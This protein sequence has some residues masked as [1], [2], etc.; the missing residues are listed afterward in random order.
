MGGTINQPRVN[1]SAG[2][3]SVAHALARRRIRASS[4]SRSCRKRRTARSTICPSI[5]SSTTSSCACR[6]TRCASVNVI[7]H[8]RFAYGID[9]REYEQHASY[10]GR[11]YED[12]Y[13]VDLATGERKL[14][15]KKRIPSRARSVDRTAQRCSTGAT[16]RSGGCSTSRP[17][18]RSASRR[19]FRRCSPTP[20]TITTTSCRRRRSR[21]AGRRT[22]ARCCSPTASTCGRCR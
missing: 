9:T 21:S 12:V 19:A 10:S 3:E 15:L 1:D 20:R 13:S 6:T 14:L 22:A 5:A 18:R 16:T 17:A 4:R 2:R 7:G 11:R 8:D